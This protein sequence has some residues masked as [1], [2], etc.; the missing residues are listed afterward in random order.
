MIDAA[1]L[2]KENDLFREK[3][4]E[5]DTHITALQEQL[6]IL[7]KNCYGSSSEKSSPDQLGLFNETEE[8]IVEKEQADEANPTTVKSHTR[9]K[10]PRTSIPDNL[11]REEI[12]HDLPES[13]KIMPT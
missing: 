3:L 11:P 13:E 5:R 1:A 10:K 2:Q 4:S 12:I 6:K 9:S 7:L 8:A